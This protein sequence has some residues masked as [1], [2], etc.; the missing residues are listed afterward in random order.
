MFIQFLPIG[1]LFMRPSSFRAMS[2]TFRPSNLHLNKSTL[3]FS[4]Y[5]RTA[6]S[7][8]RFNLFIPLADLKACL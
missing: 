7:I 3:S 8:S 5:F 6:I 2:G 4:V 1:C